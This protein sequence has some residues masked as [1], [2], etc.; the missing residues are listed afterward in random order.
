MTDLSKNV[1]PKHPI[2]FRWACS[3]SSSLAARLC[4]LEDRPPLNK[5]GGTQKKKKVGQTKYEGGGRKRDGRW[6]SGLRDG[7]GS[8]MG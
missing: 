2:P 6:E 1:R 7:G 8:A 4:D 5:N 3:L